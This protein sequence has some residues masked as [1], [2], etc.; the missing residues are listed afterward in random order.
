MEKKLQ[1]YADVMSG[2]LF[3][4]ASIFY[5]RFTSYLPP[6]SFIFPFNEPNVA[7]YCCLSFSFTASNTS[8]LLSTR[9]ADPSLC[10]RPSAK[11]LPHLDST[12][13][14]SMVVIYPWLSST[15]RRPPQQGFNMATQHG[16]AWLVIPPPLS[17]TF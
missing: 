3:T 11:T 1:K 7:H 15:P 17:Q 5:N 10:P 16:H 12:S 13:S 8:H 14:I 6:P 4:S 2:I 9:M